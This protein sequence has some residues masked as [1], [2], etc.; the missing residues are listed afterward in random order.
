MDKAKHEYHDLQKTIQQLATK[1]I[2]EKSKLERSKKTNFLIHI[3]IFY[4]S[5]YRKKCDAAK[6]RL[7]SLQQ[8]AKQYRELMIKLT[9]NSE[10]RYTYNKTKINSI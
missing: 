3:L 2:N 9:G 5:E 6:V 7:D 1:N 4:F 8:K 10:K